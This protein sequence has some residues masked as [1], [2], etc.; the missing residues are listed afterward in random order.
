[1]KDPKKKEKMIFGNGLMKSQLV[2]KLSL[3]PF[4]LEML[5]L[6]MEIID[7]EEEAIQEDV[8]VVH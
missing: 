7:L 3:V 2:L 5:V 1:M 6:E 8:K 4:D